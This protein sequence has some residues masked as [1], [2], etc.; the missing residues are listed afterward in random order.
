MTVVN[1]H[2]GT[3]DRGNPR[4][5]GSRGCITVCPTD[6]EGFFSN[7]DFSGSNSTTG[8]SSGNV[9]L[10]RNPED[11][12]VEENR[13]SLDR[14]SAINNSPQNMDWSGAN[15]SREQADLN[16]RKKIKESNPNMVWE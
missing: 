1:V 7:F 3:S 12:S 2:E 5:R 10:S 11:F 9:N 16:T 15:T 4:S 6:A 8:N 13:V 14:Q